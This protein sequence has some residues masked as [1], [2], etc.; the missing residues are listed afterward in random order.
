MYVVMKISVAHNNDIGDATDVLCF[1]CLRVP[2][3]VR[4][5]EDG[6][7]NVL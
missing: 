6:V 2:I 5:D 1:V 7:Q 4:T 3:Y